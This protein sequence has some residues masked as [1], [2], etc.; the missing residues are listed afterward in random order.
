MQG[1]FSK[2]A[3]PRSIPG[4]TSAP[5]AHHLPSW[6]LRPS[7]RPLLN[8][9]QPCAGGGAPAVSYIRGDSRAERKKNALCLPGARPEPGAPSQPLLAGFLRSF[10]G[11]GCSWSASGGDEGSS[12]SRQSGSGPAA[13]ALALPRQRLEHVPHSGR[14]SWKRSAGLA[15]TPA[16]HGAEGGRTTRAPTQWVTSVLKPRSLGVQA[17]VAS[18]SLCSSSASLR[19]R[20]KRRAVWGGVGGVSLR[21]KLGEQVDN[22]LLS[23]DGT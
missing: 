1:D 7:S 19:S 14:R 3:G 22:K 2:L 23:D 6:V 5:P 20:G 10:S 21:E 13:V 8:A 11:L 18:G 17:R 9:L 15:P 4:S 12:G 16:A